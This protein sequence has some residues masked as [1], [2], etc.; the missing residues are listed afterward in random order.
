MEVLGTLHALG[1]PLTVDNLLPLLAA[2]CSG[3]T[4]MQEGT[5][6]LVQMVKV[7]QAVNDHRR[8]GLP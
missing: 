1:Q 4:R 2:P 6:A 5:P 3:G 7:A 8:A